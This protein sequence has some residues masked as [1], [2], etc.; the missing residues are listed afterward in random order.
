MKKNIIPSTNT[1]SLRKKKRINYIEVT[2]R[3]PKSLE[4]TAKEK[5][6]KA[7]KELYNKQERKIHKKINDKFNPKKQQH[8]Y[9]TRQ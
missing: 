5:R 6:T 7:T 3:Q 9:P 8:R 4:V 2:Q 1:Y